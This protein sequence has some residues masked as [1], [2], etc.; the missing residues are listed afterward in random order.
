M[1]KFGIAIATVLIS[2]LIGCGGGS[3]S[4]EANITGNWNANLTDSNGQ[5]VY[6]FGTSFTETS[7]TNVTVVNLT[8]S[9]Q[10]NCF[11]AGNY[12]ETASA[13][14]SGDFNGNVSGSLNLTVNSTNPT[15]NTL[16]LMGTVK[17]NTIS[18]TWS[19]NGTTSG[20]TND[21]GSFTMSRS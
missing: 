7:G 19:L 15:G 10:N 1:N 11:T 20:C 8:F 18:G 17:N 4:T 13:S 21:S 3:S 16:T 9:S 14:L 2:L 6:G 5:T 12:T